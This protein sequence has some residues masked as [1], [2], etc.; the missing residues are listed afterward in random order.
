MT[1]G[2]F[3]LVLIALAPGLPLALVLA[4]IVPPL[5]ATVGRLLPLAPL[6]ALALAV[7]GHDGLALSLDYMLLGSL[8]GIQALTRVFLGFTAVLWIAGAIHARGY[9][10][11]DPHR[12]R[13]EVFW[14]AAL[15]GNIGLIVALDIATFYLFF[16]LMTFSAYGLVIHKRDADSLRAGRL[17]LVMA[18]LGEGLILTG[19]LLAAHANSLI[20]PFV[21]LIADL[22][23]AIL[24]SPHQDFIIACLWLGFGVKAGLPLLHMWLPLAHPVAPIPASA[25]LSGAMIKAGVLAWLLLLPLGLVHAPA[26]GSLIVAIGIAAALGAAVVGV[27]QHTAKTVLAYSSISQMGF[28]S[29]AVG[30]A[31]LDPTLWSLLAPVAALYALHHGLAKG[32]LFLGVA[33]AHHPGGRLGAA[34]WAALAL[35]GLL[36]AGVLPSGI[37]AKLGLKEILKMAGD[38]PGWWA[39]LPV[40][41]ACAALGTT[42]L[43]AR[44]LYLLRTPLDNARAPTRVWL[45]WLLALA[46]ALAAPFLLPVVE[47][48]GRWPGSL[49]E[50]MDLAWPPLLGVALA[51]WAWRG[52]WRPLPIPA[53][54]VL[55]VIEAVVRAFRHRGRASWGAVRAHAAFLPLLPRNTLARR[56]LHISRLSTRL[57]TRYQRD[58]ALGLAAIAV[59]LMLAA[60]LVQLPGR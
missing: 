37:L 13:F 18:V 56:I 24:I 48:G 9:L 51:V 12:S 41:L 22:P 54:D 44:Y 30:A 53:G 55:L 1:T 10:A 40:L 16:A 29:V 21:P 7:F 35:P 49:R 3:D 46:A 32:A 28:L 50:I 5:R 19:L 23:A 26:W 39:W 2:L 6:P 47:W 43:I 27:Q 34:T 60:L 57:E 58:A 45:G 36:L 8:I 4:W 17:Y 20:T 42:L 14:L 52:Q 33:I 31:L 38:A 11:D 25:V 15:S 59:V